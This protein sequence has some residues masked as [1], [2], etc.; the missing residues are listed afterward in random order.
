MDMT[1]QERERAL[2]ESMKVDHGLKTVPFEITDQRA[3]EQWLQPHKDFPTL[4]EIN[5]VIKDVR[6]EK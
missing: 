2:F 4:D 3:A 1:K 6:N 5:N